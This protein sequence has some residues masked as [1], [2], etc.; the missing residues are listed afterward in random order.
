GATV[1]AAVG[2]GVGSIVGSGVV[3]TGGSN[4]G[5]GDAVADAGGEAV[6][7]AMTACGVV[8]AESTAVLVGCV[9]ASSRPAMTS[10]T[11]GSASKANG[12]ADDRRRGA[13]GATFGRAGRC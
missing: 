8:V 7:V 11:R 1:G 6:A 9:R 4:V 3:S 12:S 13:G 5:S 2:S 10:V